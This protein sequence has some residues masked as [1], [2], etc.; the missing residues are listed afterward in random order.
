VT[1]GVELREAAG[2]SAAAARWARR[3]A[4]GGVVAVA[5]P[6]VGVER[7]GA[8][9]AVVF[10][11]ERILRDQEGAVGQI[12]REVVVAGFAGGVVR[13]LQAAAELA[14]HRAGGAIRA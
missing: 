6:L 10:E 11:H 2:N 7:G 12:E 1:D 13:R 8:A 4:A 3:K 9:Q 14:G 5:V